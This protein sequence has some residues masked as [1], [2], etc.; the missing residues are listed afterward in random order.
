MVRKV[1]KD[2]TAEQNRGLSPPKKIKALEVRR[3]TEHPLRLN[4]RVMAMKICGIF[5]V[6]ASDEGR[7]PDIQRWNSCAPK[8]KS[9]RLKI[10]CT[11]WVD[12]ISG[13]I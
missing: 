2:G 1:A 10:K 5:G 6:V 12:G 4:I 3:S 11:Q 8:M 13:K 7:I 9:R